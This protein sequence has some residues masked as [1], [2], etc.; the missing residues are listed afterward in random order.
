MALV[1]MVLPGSWGVARDF[2]IDSSLVC[3][4]ICGV[5]VHTKVEQSN[6]CGV[7]I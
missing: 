2:S 6:D 4:V 5:N 1:I 7:A 3:L